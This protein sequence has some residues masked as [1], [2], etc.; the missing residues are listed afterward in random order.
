MEKTI[1]PANVL[2]W[3]IIA[4]ALCWAPILGIIFAAIGLKK[5]KTYKR[6]VDLPSGMAKTGKILSAI[7]LPVSIVMLIFWII[8]AIGIGAMIAYM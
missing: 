1:T 5:A 8:Y 4:I 6:T 3:G 2:T 7:A